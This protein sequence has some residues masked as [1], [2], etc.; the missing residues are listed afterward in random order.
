MQQ[1]TFLV[2][3]MVFLL[4]TA[5]TGISY[6]L[7]YFYP[8]LG[9]HREYLLV[10]HSMVSLYGWNL[11]GVFVMIRWRDFPIRLNSALAIALHWAIVIVLAPLGKY[12]LLASVLAMAAYVALLL[13]VF[14]GR[15][16]QKGADR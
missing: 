6:I 11:S 1:K 14:G 12:V 5:L 13:I 8:S 10:L 2:S 9:Q 4:F 7:R 16:G 3:G 15:A